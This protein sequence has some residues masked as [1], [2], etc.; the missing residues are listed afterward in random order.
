MN[1]SLIFKLTVE[2]WLFQGY[3]KNRYNYFW[4]GNSYIIRHW[5][6]CKV[7]RKGKILFKENF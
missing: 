5:I 2:I 6:G 7:D 4:K 1:K 3:N